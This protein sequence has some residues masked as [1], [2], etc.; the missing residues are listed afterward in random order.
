MASFRR[1]FRSA[2]RRTWCDQDERARGWY[3]GWTTTCMHVGLPLHPSIHLYY[4]YLAQRVAQLPHQQP[5]PLL[6][7]GAAQGAGERGP[8][9]RR[10]QAGGQRQCRRVRLRIHHSARCVLSGRWILCGGGSLTVRQLGVL[11]VPSPSRSRWSPTHTQQ[12]TARASSFS[13]TRLA[14]RSMECIEGSKLSWHQCC[15]GA[16]NGGVVR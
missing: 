14:I 13:K 7:G 15:Q 4:I 9:R 6:R 3:Q 5:E 12:E 11:R 2:R 16:V 8:Q 1:R 10:R